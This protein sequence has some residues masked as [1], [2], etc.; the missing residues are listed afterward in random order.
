VTDSQNLKRKKTHRSNEDNWAAVVV[1]DLTIH[2][3]E[4]KGGVRVDGTMFPRKAASPEAWIIGVGLPL[5][6]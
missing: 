5:R 2:L 6:S 3:I 1:K 4:I